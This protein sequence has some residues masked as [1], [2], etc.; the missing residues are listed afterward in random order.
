M[1]GDSRKVLILVLHLEQGL[2]KKHQPTYEKWVAVDN[3]IKQHQWAAH[4]WG[5]LVS[6]TGHKWPGLWIAEELHGL[7]LVSSKEITHY[8]YCQLKF[9]I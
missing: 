2:W 7:K 3:W 8:N 5:E 9:C 1:R 4:A 6:L